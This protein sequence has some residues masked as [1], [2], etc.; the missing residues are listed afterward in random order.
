MKVFNLRKR[1]E[2]KHVYWKSD[3]IEFHPR[4]A[5][6]MTKVYKAGYHSGRAQLCCTVTTLLGIIGL[7]IS[8]FI[9]WWFAASMLAV[10]LFI[11]WGEL[12]L[13]LPIVTKYSGCDPP[14]WGFYFYGE[15][16]KIPD[17]IGI[18]KGKK[19]KLIDLPWYPEWVRTSRMAKD[20]SWLHERK[21]DRKRGIDHDWWSEATQAKL[22]KET[23]DYTYVLKSGEV[24]E[25]KATITVEQ[26]EWRPKWFM[27][28]SLFAK[29]R[30]N[31]DI[32]FDKEVGER[33]GS[34]KGGTVGCGWDL[35]P[36][37]TPLE[38]LRRMEKERVFR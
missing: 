25:R 7:L 29:I 5:K 37:E 18:C 16:K 27:W 21:G 28:A 23:H 36:N 26:R 11:P 38:C 17:T 14:S 33:T 24:Q 32:E 20:C 4:F 6:A 9:G 12:Y 8:P 22:W 31:I 3:D 35:L 2:G 10:V 30:T 15:G 1:V 34:W 19:T 13:K